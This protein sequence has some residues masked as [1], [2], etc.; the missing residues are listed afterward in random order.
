MAP[1]KNRNN[2]SKAGNR[3]NHTSRR[4]RNRLD[5]RSRWM[6]KYYSLTLLGWLTKPLSPLSLD[7]SEEEPN[8]TSSP[9][10]P[11]PRNLETENGS[12]SMLLAETPNEPEFAAPSIQLFT[13][14]RLPQVE[15]D[16]SQSF[17][18]AEE[19][20]GCLTSHHLPNMIHRVRQ[21]QLCIDPKDFVIPYTPIAV[22]E[23]LVG[24]DEIR[25]VVINTCGMTS[26]PYTLHDDDPF[27]TKYPNHTT[28]LPPISTFFNFHRRRQS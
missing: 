14:K 4:T 27:D 13:E 28:L 1:I 8:S 6:K 7:D 22:Q 3:R 24:T 16:N 10:T 18:P 21:P 19:S 11:S 17:L 9:S 20:D 2:R 5:F 23:K 25:T 12:G 26:L 15:S